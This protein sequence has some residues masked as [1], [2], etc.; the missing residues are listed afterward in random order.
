M[1]AYIF[2]HCFQRAIAFEQSGRVQAASLL[3][4]GLL[5]AKRLWQ[6]E[7]GLSIDLE[8]VLDA[9]RAERLKRCQ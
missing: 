6:S 2:R 7:Q 9:R 4:K 8:S 5:Q 3:E 1:T